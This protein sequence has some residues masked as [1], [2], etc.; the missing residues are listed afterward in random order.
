MENVS[1]YKDLVIANTRSIFK[2]SPFS[3]E[4]LLG[5]F[6]RKLEILAVFS[7][8][9]CFL[10][11]V[12]FEKFIRK[13]FLRGKLI[14][15]RKIFKIDFDLE[16]FFNKIWIICLQRKNPNFFRKFFWVGIHL[17]KT[18]SEKKTYVLKNFPMTIF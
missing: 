8:C 10:Q 1:N 6:L 13:F 14:I 16:R 9:R 3:I 17:Q 4:S 7:Y 15:Q 2:Y 18:F 12:Y 5:N 11:E